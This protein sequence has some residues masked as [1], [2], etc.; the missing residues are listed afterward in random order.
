MEPIT[1]AEIEAPPEACWWDVTLAHF[2]YVEQVWG[3]TA[4]EAK[5]KARC[6]WPKLIVVSAKKASPKKP[7]IYHVKEE[8]PN[9]LFVA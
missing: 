5:S 2:K 3:K 1:D 8:L 7:N 9:T 6:R 4:Q